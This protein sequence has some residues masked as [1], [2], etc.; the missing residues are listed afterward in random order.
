[1][2]LACGQFR[3]LCPMSMYPGARPC[4][5]ARLQPGRKTRITAIGLQ[6]LRIFAALLSLSAYLTHAQSSPNHSLKVQLDP[7]RT[8]IHWKVSG[9]RPIHGDFKLKNGEFLV[10]PATGVAEGEILVDA[11]TP[12]TSDAG[13]RQLQEQV[14]ESHRY[15]GIIFH[16]S[17]F[18]GGFPVGEGA[19]DVV[20]DGSFNIHG[21]DHPLQIP[22]K[23]QLSSGALTATTRFAVPYVAWGMKYPGTFFHRLGKQVEVQIV[24][25]GN[26]QQVE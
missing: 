2:G 23:V 11:T 24:A 7:A 26:V 6:P 12:Q 8:E 5:R 14:L 22:F 15:P 10:N 9:L 3:I 20:A 4:I 17:T 21:E 1:V 25:R 18:K 19:H 16:P 13:D